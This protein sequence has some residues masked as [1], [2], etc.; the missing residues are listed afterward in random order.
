MPELAEVEYFRKQWDAGL[1]KKV[2]SV[3]LHKG[4]QLFRGVDE[5]RLAA[6]LQGATYLRSEA[7]AKLMCFRF[8]RDAWLGIHLGMTGELRV[9]PPDFRQHHR[10]ERARRG[11][12][13]QGA[14]QRVDV[15]FGG[16]GFGRRHGHGQVRLDSPEMGARARARPARARK[17]S[18][19][20]LAREWPSFTE[21]SS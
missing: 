14:Q 20:T 17:M 10:S 4:K 1:R 12:V 8:S 19:F 18:V 9:E 15:A 16:V 6:A 7:R 3:A 11:P 5:K 21:I 13:G 2:V